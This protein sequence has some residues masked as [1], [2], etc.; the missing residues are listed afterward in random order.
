MGWRFRRSVKLLPGVRLNV[1]KRSLSVSAGPRGG[2]VSLNT[3]GEVR[4]TV[5][6]PGTGLSHTTQTQLRPSTEDELEQVPVEPTVEELAYLRGRAFRKVVGWGSALVVVVLIL[7]GAATAAGYLLIPAV[8][9]TIIA[10]W[11][12]RRF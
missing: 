8:V 10:P 5:G 9:L 2:K 11:L 12:S 6:L 1:G 4:R 3:K 7:A